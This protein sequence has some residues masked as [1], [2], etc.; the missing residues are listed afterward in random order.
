MHLVVLDLMQLRLEK[1][2]PLDGLLLGA[3]ELPTNH[4]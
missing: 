2:R 3:D 1:A 4:D